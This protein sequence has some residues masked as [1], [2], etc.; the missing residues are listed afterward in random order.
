MEF[1]KSSGSFRSNE[2]RV[3]GGPVGRNPPANA[4][5][6]GSSLVLGDPHA[7]RAASAPAP[8]L[9]SARCSGWKPAP[10]ACAPRGSPRGAKSSRATAT[11]ARR[12]GEDPAQPKIHKQD[13]KTSFFKRSGGSDLPGGPVIWV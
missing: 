13:L 7:A 12:S 5:D 11:K 6:V 2:W 1:F 4:G 8:Q 9:R 3:P 10:A